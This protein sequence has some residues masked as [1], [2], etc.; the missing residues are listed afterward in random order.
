MPRII[1]FTLKNM[2]S[3]EAIRLEDVSLKLIKEQNEVFVQFYDDNIIDKKFKINIESS[4][5][6]MKIR[7]N[8]KIRVFDL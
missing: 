2:F 6:D 4:K 8:K 3:L 5:E 7:F 1:I